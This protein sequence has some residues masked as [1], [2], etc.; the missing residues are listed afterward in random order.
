MERF[1]S[2]VDG[3]WYNV[4]QTV[5]VI[6]SLLGLISSLRMTAAAARR[7][8]EAK[9]RDAI[10]REISNIFTQSEH[11]SAL[12][13]ELEQNPEL[14]RVLLPDLD[15][16]KRPASLLEHVFINKVFTEYLTSWR[17]ANAGGMITLDELAVDAKW[18]FTLPLP[19]AVWEKT[20]EF[21]NREF[22]QFVD[23]AIEDGGRLSNYRNARLCDV[24]I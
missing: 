4:V 22:V 11:H 13:G 21:K 15:V 23:R 12:W 5:G 19:H 14:Q 24:K 10:A 18:F 2:W 1:S 9:R 20:K 17:V 7:E 6:G 8:A 16:S 3:N